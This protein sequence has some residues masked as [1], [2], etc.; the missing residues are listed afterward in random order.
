MS[1]LSLKAELALIPQK[2]NTHNTKSPTPNRSPQEISLQSHSRLGKTAMESESLR[3]SSE[4]AESKSIRA[5]D[6]MAGKTLDQVNE[7]AFIEVIDIH[8][9]LDNLDRQTE[10]FLKLSALFAVDVKSQSMGSYFSRESSS[11]QTGT[12]KC[13]EQ[14]DRLQDAGQS[15]HNTIGQLK[16]STV[17]KKIEIELF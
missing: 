10:Q 17:M 16:Y 4:M 6:S 1:E 12:S 7:D 11:Y 5:F 8:Q 15:I 13:W 14:V 3:N 9:Y 2:P